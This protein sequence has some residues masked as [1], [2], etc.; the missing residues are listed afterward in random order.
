[1]KAKFMKGYTR[2][3]MCDEWY[4]PNSERARVHDHPEPQSGPPRDAWLRS[5]LRYDEWIDKT[6]EGRAWAKASR[7][8]NCH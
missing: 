1:M 4:D 8:P 5:G 2:C 7:A 3:A 6:I